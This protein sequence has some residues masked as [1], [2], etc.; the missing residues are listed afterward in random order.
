MLTSNTAPSLAETRLALT[1]QEKSQSLKS[2]LIGL[3][4]TALNLEDEQ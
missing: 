1:E 3:L 4:C 2:G